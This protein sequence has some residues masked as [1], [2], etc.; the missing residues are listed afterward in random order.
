MGEEYY[1]HCTVLEQVNLS[2]EKLPHAGQLKQ[3]FVFLLKNTHC[4][5]LYIPWD[6]ET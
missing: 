1:V 4:V 5:N 3:V 2:C 6:I